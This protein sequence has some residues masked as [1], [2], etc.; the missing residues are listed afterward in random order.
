MGKAWKNKQTVT[1]APAEKGG[2]GMI[3]MDPYFQSQ[4][5]KKMPLGNFWLKS[6]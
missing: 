3:D 2:L 5:E 4:Q 1:Y 6:I